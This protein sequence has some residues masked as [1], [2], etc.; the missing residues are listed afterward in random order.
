MSKRYGF[1]L[2]MAGIALAATAARGEDQ[3]T[4][5]AVGDGH[6]K[7]LAPAAWQRRQP[8]S[9]IVEYEFAVPKVE[10]DAQDGRLTVMGAGGS[11][12]ANIERWIGQFTQP[13]GKTTKERT[14]VD[15]KQVDGAVVHRVDITGSFVDRPGGPFA[16]GR[17]VTRPNYRMLGAIIVTPKFGQHFVK[18]YGPRAT[19]AAN[20][21]RFQQFIDSLRVD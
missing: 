1:A 19:I 2:L 15:K 10:G 21:Q 8:R 18:L 20:E 13:D 12:E 14:T 5:I 3:A 6:V 4:P 16:P 17:A 9:R 11:V 7:L